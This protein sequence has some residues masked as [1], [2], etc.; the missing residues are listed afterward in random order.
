MGLIPTSRPTW[1]RNS[2]RILD[3]DLHILNDGS[4][5]RT[6]RISGNDSWSG[7]QHQNKRKIIYQLLWG[8]SSCHGISIIL[9]IHQQQPSFNLRTLCTESKSLCEA[10]ISSNPW[11]FPIHNFIN[12]ISSFIFIQ[13]IPGHSAIPSNNLAD[14]AVKESTVIA[15]DTDLPVS[16]PSSIQVINEA[17]YITLPT[18]KHVALVY[19]HWRVSHVALSRSV[20]EKMTFSLLLYGPAI[21][22]LSG[23]TSTDLIHLKIDLLELPPR[24]TRSPSLA[25]WISSFDHH[26]TKS[27]WEPSRVLRVACHSTWGCSGVRKKDPGQPWHLT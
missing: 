10:F 4:D 16:L 2:R 17:I 1:R 24:S 25:L 27:V 22:L 8:G 5:T 14:E 20:T 3:N 21:T 18:H 7:H 11:T 19:R 6:S 15:T 12:S 26:K 13:W 23:N 9:D